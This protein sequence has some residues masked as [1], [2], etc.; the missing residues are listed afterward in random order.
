VKHH[1]KLPVGTKVRVTSGPAKDMY[2]GQVWVTTS[3]PIKSS[4][5]WLVWVEGAH[6]NW[7]KHLFYIEQ[8]EVIDH[9]LL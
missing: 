5:T 9:E 6:D 1:I 3:K 2:A 4:G 8:L 7:I